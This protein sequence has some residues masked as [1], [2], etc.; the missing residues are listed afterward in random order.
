MNRFVY[1]SE[2]TDDV[3]SVIYQANPAAV[4]KSQARKLENGTWQYPFARLSGLT[5]HASFNYYTRR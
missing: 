3:V 2:N 1:K 4:D 5:L